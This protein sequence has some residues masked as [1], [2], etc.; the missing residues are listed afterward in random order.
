VDK[1]GASSHLTLDSWKVI[2]NEG[3]RGVDHR[4]CEK[5]KRKPPIEVA[6]AGTE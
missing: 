3:A 5:F 1:V 2:H 6:A 4:N